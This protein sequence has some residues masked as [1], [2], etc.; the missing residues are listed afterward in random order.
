MKKKA[1]KKKG[2][3]KLPPFMEKIMKKKAGKKKGK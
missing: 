3:K 1:G 2:E